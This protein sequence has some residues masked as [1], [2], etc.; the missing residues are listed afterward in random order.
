MSIAVIGTS[1][2]DQVIDTPSLTPEICNKCQI[3]TTFG[4]SMRNIAENLAHLRQQVL[5]ATT[6]GSDAMA[7][8]L[9]QQ[10]TS[11]GVSVL[12]HQ[13][14]L[15]SPFFTSIYYKN[16]TF[17]FASVDP[18]FH[19]TTTNQLPMAA[20]DQCAYGVTDIADSSLL[21]DLVLHTAQ[22]K[23][24]LSANY[25]D[26]LASFQTLFPMLYGIVM[27]EEEAVSLANGLSYQQLAHQLLEQNL[28]RVIVTLADQGVY[29][30]DQDQELHL[31]A[32]DVPKPHYT[33]GCG[34]AFISGYLTAIHSNMQPMDALTWGMHA[35][36]IKL[37]HMEPVSAEIGRLQIKQ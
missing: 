23:W 1:I 4:G 26:D 30:L 14:D 7:K 22:T 16:E 3:K 28:L 6:L 29:Y 35:A 36:A 15:P 11:L 8:A 21:S 34:D 25:I 31:P 5:F 18:S 10:L 17:R 33:I 37:Q 2:I 19:I 9:E 12:A 27:N 13:V 24:M 20:F 32:F